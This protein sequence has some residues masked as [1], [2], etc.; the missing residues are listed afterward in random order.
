[1]ET[2]VPITITD[3]KLTN[4]RFR[5]YKTLQQRNVDSMKRQNEYPKIADEHF[6]SKKVKRIIII[7]RLISNSI[8]LNSYGEFTKVSFKDLLWLLRQK[9]VDE[10]GSK[11]ISYILTLPPWR[12]IGIKFI[13]KFRSKKANLEY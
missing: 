4:Y 11:V 12:N 7:I 6:K 2:N 1:M 8:L 9:D 5:N 13:K 10:K 3:Q